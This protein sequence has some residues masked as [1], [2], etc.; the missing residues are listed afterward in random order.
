MKKIGFLIGF[1]CIIMGSLY[2]FALPPLL[3]VIIKAELTRKNIKLDDLGQMDIGLKHVTLR[4]TVLSKGP[5]NIEISA[6]NIINSPL[7]LLIKKRARSLEIISAHI[8]VDLE[9]DTST[10][11]QTGSMIK[12]FMQHPHKHVSSLLDTAVLAL[13]RLSPSITFKDI[14]LNIHTPYGLISVKG[15][16]HISQDKILASFSS[17]Q[18]QLTFNAQITGDLND[19][20]KLTS[21]IENINVDV[22]GYKVKRGSGKFVYSADTKSKTNAQSFTVNAG[23][24]K[25]KDLPLNNAQLKSDSRENQHKIYVEATHSPEASDKIQFWYNIVENQATSFL[26]AQNIQADTVFDLYSQASLKSTAALYR[27]LLGRLFIHPTDITVQS[28][29]QQNTAHYTASVMPG[30][31]TAL[32]KITIDS[33]R[34]Q[35]PIMYVTPFAPNPTQVK[36]LAQYFLHT[37]PYEFS[38]SAEIFGHFGL[39]LQRGGIMSTFK[40]HDPLTLRLKNAAFKSDKSSATNINGLIRLVQDSKVESSLSFAALQTHDLK[41]RDGR[42]HFTLGHAKPP[43]LKLQQMRATLG[44]GALAII[45]DKSTRGYDITGKRV[46][47]SSIPRVFWPE[48]TTLSELVDVNAKLHAMA[49][50]KITA[51]FNY[52]VLRNAIGSRQTFSDIDADHKTYPYIKFMEGIAP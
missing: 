10:I 18:K 14:A 38:G 5:Y 49:N 15:D 51:Q 41:L 28:S 25:I 44:T 16:S 43:Y 26:Q 31:D 8:F 2:V 22:D 40:H 29:H 21:Y 9:N 42:I 17:I 48:N 20:I 32:T 33:Q 50:D 30:K 6:I 23:M 52:S 4:N 12:I 35:P 45:E 19:K 39:D 47:A 46:N 37:S 11:K 36:A 3:E 24:V 34:N 1:I 7:T 27:S 13:Y